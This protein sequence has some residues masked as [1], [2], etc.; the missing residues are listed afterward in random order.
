VA[1]ELAAGL[2]LGGRARKVSS[3]A[4]RAR[5]NVRKR[6]LDAITRIGEHNPALA[7]YLEQ[8]VKTGTFCS[9]RPAR[10]L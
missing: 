2:G 1:R 4:E 3:N 9:Y 8:T 10:R 7:K 5:V 6:V